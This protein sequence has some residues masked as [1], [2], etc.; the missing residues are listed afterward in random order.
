VNAPCLTAVADAGATATTY[1]CLCC[2]AEYIHAQSRFRGPLS[3]LEVI[4]ST[5]NITD[6]QVKLEQ[7]KVDAEAAKAENELVRRRFRVFCCR[8]LS[9]FR[10]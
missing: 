3:Q 2:F 5:K 10:R 1:R 6:A 4:Q 9:V 8:R 7:L